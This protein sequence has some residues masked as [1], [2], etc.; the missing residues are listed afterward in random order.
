MGFS[1]FFAAARVPRELV[2]RLLVLGEGDELQ[3][4]EGFLAALESR[5][6]PLALGIL[7]SQEYVGPRPHVEL[8]AAHDAHRRRLKRLRPRRILVIGRAEGAAALLSQV[9]CRSDW[10]NASSPETLRCGCKAV[11]VAN[12]RHA[13]AMP[14]ATLTGDPNL[15]LQSLPEPD[16]DASLCERFDEYRERQH[17][18]FYA[19][20]TGEGEEALAYACL[21]E[22]LRKH[23]AI[24]LLAPR[25]PQRYEPVY[26]D[27]IKYSMPTI[28]HSRLM[29]SYVPRKN[30]VYFVETP[31]ALPLLYA[32]ADVVIPGGSLAA[33]SALT[34]DLITPLALGR[35]VLAGPARDAWTASAL[36]AEAI[37]GAEDVE[38]LAAQALELMRSPEQA[39]AL[40][41]RGRAWLERQIGA[42]A[43]VLA[44]LEE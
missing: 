41:A 39:A 23:T 4:A 43:R 6:G 26:R 3:H 33:Q 1:D 9:S 19:A 38:G 13:E 40:G 42:R 44:L 28:R 30:R 15:E 2:G 11:T 31:E 22:I 5:L 8:P 18:V 7:G 29:T 27:A 34:P 21:F 10:V 20:G 35:P 12:T 14:Q 25:D 32:C 16:R 24:L 17:G 36:D 37:A